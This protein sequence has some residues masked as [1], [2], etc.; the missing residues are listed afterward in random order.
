MPATDAKRRC[1]APLMPFE[2]FG[3]ILWEMQAKQGKALQYKGYEF[4]IYAIFI[5]AFVAF[6]GAKPVKRLIFCEIKQA[7]HDTMR[8]YKRGWVLC[9]MDGN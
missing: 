9:W 1:R 8:K 7:P 2:I 6:G 5:F 4:R 3:G